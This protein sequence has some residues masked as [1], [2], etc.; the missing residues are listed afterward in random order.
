MYKVFMFGLNEDRELQALQWC[1]CCRHYTGY[2]LFLTYTTHVADKDY[3]HV[4]L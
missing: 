3:M 4:Y 2:V 1:I